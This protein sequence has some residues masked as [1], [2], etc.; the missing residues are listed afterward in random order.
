MIMACDS[1]HSYV[2]AYWKRISPC[3]ASC[4][5][6]ISANLEC[7]HLGSFQSFWIMVIER[8]N[9]SIIIGAALISARIISWGT[10]ALLLIMQVVVGVSK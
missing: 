10:D 1:N 8:N 6:D 4:L 2:S 5:D 7:L 9:A 3:S